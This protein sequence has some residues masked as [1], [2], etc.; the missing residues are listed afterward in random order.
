MDTILSI[1]SNEI[2]SLIWKPLALVLTIAGLWGIFK[3]AGRPGWLSIIPVYNIV[4]LLQ[5]VG[6][7]WW[8]LLLFLI[9]FSADSLPYAGLTVSRVY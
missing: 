6:K 1:F 2:V 8:W 4:V 7:P 9:P 5:V 3:K